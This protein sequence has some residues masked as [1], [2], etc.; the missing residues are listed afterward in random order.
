MSSAERPDSET[1]PLSNSIT[2]K[3]TLLDENFLVSDQIYITRELDDTRLFKRFPFF[4]KKGLSESGLQE[5][6][7]LFGKIEAAIELKSTLKATGKEYQV[8]NE[9]IK[10]LANPIDNRKSELFEL[11]ELTGGSVNMCVLLSGLKGVPGAHRW[12]D[13]IIRTSGGVP[14]YSKDQ[15]SAS[16]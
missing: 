6:C 14:A 12:V 16:G 8:L 1:K 5:M 2:L 11:Y 3:S 7:Y 15:N 10:L 9:K 13:F 4:N